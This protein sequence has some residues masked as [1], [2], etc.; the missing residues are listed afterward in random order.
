MP[1]HITRVYLFEKL[2]DLAKASAAG[3]AWVQSQRCVRKPPVCS[4]ACKQLIRAHWGGAHAAAFCACIINAL[5]S[6]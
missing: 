2:R 4:C 1:K 3:R 5:L 6:D